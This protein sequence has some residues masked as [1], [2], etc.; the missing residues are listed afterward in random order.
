MPVTVRNLSAPEATGSTGRH[1][2]DRLMDRFRTQRFG[3]ARDRNRVRPCLSFWMPVQRFSVH[4]PI[5]LRLRSKY[6]HAGERNRLEFCRLPQPLP[7]LDEFLSQKE[8]DG[9]EF[10]AGKE[11]WLKGLH[12][13]NFQNFYRVV[14][15]EV[16][17]LSQRAVKLVIAKEDRY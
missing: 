1:V 13:L 15:Q 16:D 6:Q 10:F 2:Q 14:T 12:K 17:D 5:H 4:P 7:S 8:A 3:N 11:P 9:F